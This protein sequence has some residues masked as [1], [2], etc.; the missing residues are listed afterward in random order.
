M[1]SRLEAA[2][3]SENREGGV[4][5]RVA[6]AV[7]HILAAPQR[8]GASRQGLKQHLLHIGHCRRDAG[9]QIVTLLIFSLAG[10]ALS[11][12]AIE[13]FPS[14]VAMIAEMPLM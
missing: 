2:R 6:D 7:R 11:L 5:Q 9:D 12:L 10:L 8:S 3:S 14:F 13:R 1:D 4:A